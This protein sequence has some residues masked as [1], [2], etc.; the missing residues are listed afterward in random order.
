M[1]WFWVALLSAVLFAVSAVI[2]KK[3][4]ENTSPVFFTALYTL[5][6][7]VFYIPFFLYFIQGEGLPSFSG[8]TLFILLS[9]VTNGLGLLLY[10]V[11]IK[12]EDVSIVMPLNRFQPVFVAVIGFLFLNEAVT[13]Q[14]AAGVVL[15]TL[16]GYLVLLKDKT[17]FKAPLQHLA[18]SRGAQMALL[19]AVVFS[20][21]AVSDRY[22]TQQI[23]PEIHTFFILLAM[24]VTF[25]GYMLKNDGR[26]YIGEAKDKLLENRNIYLFMGLIG[27]VSYLAVYIAL[28]LAEAS[29]VIPVLQVQVP[30]TVLAGGALL[31]EENIA[32]KLIGSAV[33]IAG[34]IL[35]AL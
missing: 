11:S 2:S 25:N 22:V 33:L 6:S 24:T 5:L 1:Y 17:H 27:A 34:V 13:S 28:S 14:I 10:N 29:K 7:T 32:L 4:M 26:N 31:H 12:K 8:V 19:S 35:I 3:L 9:A 20:I 16:G 21:A 30:L 15:V 23:Q 18:H